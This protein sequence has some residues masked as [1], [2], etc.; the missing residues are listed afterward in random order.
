MRPETVKPSKNGIIEGEI[1]SAMPTGMETTIK[2]KIAESLITA[3]VFGGV[4]YKIGE[5][6]KI[7]FEGNGLLLF[8]RKNE[9]LI[10]LGSVELE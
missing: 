4:F 7:N 5:K 9:K 10:A 3:V 2:I 1:Y 8:S 6:I